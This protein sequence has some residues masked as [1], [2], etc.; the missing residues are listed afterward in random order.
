M[1]IKKMEMKKEIKVVTQAPCKCAGAVLKYPPKDINC[2]Y[3]CT[4]YN[5]PRYFEAQCN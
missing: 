4:D 3:D 2:F 5:K 1:K